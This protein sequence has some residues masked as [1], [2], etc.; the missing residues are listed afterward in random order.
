LSTKETQTPGGWLNA[1]AGF[2][3]TPEETMSFEQRLNRG[4]VSYASSVL[5]QVAKEE[6]KSI[7]AL[8]RFAF[9]GTSRAQRWND[10]ERAILQS[11]DEVNPI[12]MNMESTRKDTS[13][14]T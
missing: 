9:P 5:G 1:F 2:L 13:I 4:A 7:K 14:R 3:R 11:R 6:A 8:S 12:P 10:W